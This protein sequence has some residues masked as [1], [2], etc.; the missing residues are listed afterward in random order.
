VQPEQWEATQVGSI[1]RGTSELLV[2]APDEPLAKAFEQLARRDIS[3]MPVVVDGM[4]VG[5]LR[6]RD[7]TRWLELAWKPAVSA[8]PHAK[9]GERSAPQGGAHHTA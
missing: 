7:V 4:L 1:M 5:V 8:P 2:A 3:Q 6:R 9:Q